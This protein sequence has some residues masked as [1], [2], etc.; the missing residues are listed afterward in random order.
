M[1]LHRE[2]LRIIFFTLLALVGLNGLLEYAAP[3]T[4]YTTTIEVLSLMFLCT[5]CTIF[6]K[7]K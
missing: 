4:W 7:S 5:C 6:Q 3:G 1:T 2:G